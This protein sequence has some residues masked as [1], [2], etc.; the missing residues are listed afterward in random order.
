MN[1]NKTNTNGDEMTTEQ[2][3]ATI[4]AK[5]ADRTTSELIQDA[6]VSR[7][8]KADETQRMIF[9]L[10]MDTLEERLSV[11]DFEDLYELLTND[12]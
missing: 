2:L 5:L 7:A 1:G 4:K 9:A 3:H 8:L 6:E 10:I 11:E 12:N